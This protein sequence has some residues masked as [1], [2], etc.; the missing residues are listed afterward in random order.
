MQVP[1]DG[2]VA[3]LRRLLGALDDAGVEVEHLSIHS[4]NLDDVFFAVTGRPTRGGPVPAMTSM[5][6]TVAD[7]ATMTRRNLRRL[8]RYPS[9]TVLLVGM[10]IVFLVLFV[11]VFGGQL[12]HGLERRAGRRARRAGRVPELRDARDPSP[13]C[14]GCG[15]GHRHRGRHGHD[16][17]ASSTASAPWPSPGPPF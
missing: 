15:P 12:S 4:P 9:M 2:T 11:Y 7:S 1:T 17:A 10:P 6:Y 8:L 5:T 13:G 14:R 3:S 16:R